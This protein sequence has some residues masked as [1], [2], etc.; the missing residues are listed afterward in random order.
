MVK[1]VEDELSRQGGVYSLPVTN[2]NCEMICKSGNNTWK[3]AHL[4]TNN[5][6]EKKTQIRK[7]N[8]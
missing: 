5:L 7:D 3:I 1:C 8:R 2:G 4:E 6:Q